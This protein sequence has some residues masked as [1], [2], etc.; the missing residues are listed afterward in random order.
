MNDAHRNAPSQRPCAPSRRLRTTALL[1][2]AGAMIGINVSAAHADG[3]GGRQH[4]SRC[5]RRP[6]VPGMV[7]TESRQDFDD[8]WAALIGALDDNPSI[9]VVAT[10]D[11]AAAAAGA[12]LD[13][14]PNRVVVFGNP[15]LGTPIME[16]GRTAG[17]DLPQKIL[18]WE[19]RQRVFV[20]YNSVDY[21][22]ARHDVGDADTLETI[23]GALSG[24]A[25]T[26]TGDERN[27]ES[28][29][30]HDR[31]LRRVARRPG[32]VTVASDADFDT[33]WSRLLAAIEGSPAS[34]AF[35]VDHG[36]NAAG[37]LEPTRLVVFGNPNLGTPLMQRS[38]TAGI[39]LPIKIL[40]WE[41]AN[42]VTQ[43]STTDVRF[44]K[45]RHRLQHV[46]ESLDAIDGA[47]DNFVTAATSTT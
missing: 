44:L 22:A 31:V 46:R 10:V 37:V 25:A 38:P 18:V 23:A 5:H 16:V 45:R 8:T 4:G 27:C 33:T 47:I 43:V 1:L 41:D 2:L 40:V 11:H 15:A 29:W 13:L 3:S 26:A 39:D 12:G 6:H 32:V 14:E 30:R 24:L 28:R 36:A 21:L 34:V 7:V 9:T 20:G 42:G 19:D 35:T 17:L